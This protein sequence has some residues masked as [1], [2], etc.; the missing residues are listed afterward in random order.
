MDQTAIDKF[1]DSVRDFSIQYP[2]T[3]FVDWIRDT[4]ARHTF[5]L[6]LGGAIMSGYAQMRA[7]LGNW[8]P[9]LKNGLA[10]ATIACVLIAATTGIWGLVVNAPPP[11]RE[12]FS[13]GLIVGICILAGVVAFRRFINPGRAK[14][15]LTKRTLDPRVPAAAPSP[16]FK[17]KVVLTF[18]NESG[19]MIIVLP[20]RWI[21]GP[22]GVGLQTPI[23][24]GSFYYRIE[25]RSKTVELSE[26]V[27]RPM[28]LSD[29]G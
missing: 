29:F 25:V 14:L 7:R 3:A 28:K 18:I 27:L 17:A 6:T 15:S 26:L 24:N 8:Q 19:R 23:E 4:S 21:P 9:A 10:G 5:L 1:W 16:V 13:R 11:W 12:G 2:L 20:P 22:T